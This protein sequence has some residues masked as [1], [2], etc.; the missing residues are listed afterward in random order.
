MRY[1]MAVLTTCLVAAA[2]Y[3]GHHAAEAAFRGMGGGKD[4]NVPMAPVTQLLFS[5]ESFVFAFRFGL[6]GIV[7]VI[8]LAIAVA[9]WRRPE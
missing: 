5:V 8:S 6:I 7:L 3:L 9:M 2:I 4:V 1:A